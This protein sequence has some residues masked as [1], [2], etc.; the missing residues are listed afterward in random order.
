MD[1]QNFPTKRNLLLA[2]QRLILARKG[3]DLLDK[4]RLVLANELLAVEDQLHTTKKDMSSALD[5]AHKALNLAHMEM[6][7][8]KVQRACEAIPRCASVSIF[9][10]SIMGVE[11]PL[12]NSKSKDDDAGLYYQLQDTTVSFDEAILAWKLALEHIISH[13]IIE[14]T[15]SRLQHHIKKTQKRANAL[16]NITIPKYEARIKYIEERLEERE[17]D[18]LARL[19]KVKEQQERQ[20]T[21]RKSPNQPHPM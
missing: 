15:V 11:L 17:R 16:S 19:K 9:I 2:K 14:N 21:A 8:D 20:S 6:G 12:V 4:K 3:Y 7:K 1:T 18:D 5:V 10:R 13:A